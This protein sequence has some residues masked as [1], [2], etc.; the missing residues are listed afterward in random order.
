MLDICIKFTWTLWHYSLLI[1]FLGYE[2]ILKIHTKLVIDS[3]ES[4]HL[5]QSLSQKAFRC[6]EVLEE[7]NKVAATV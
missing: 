4:Q 5:L 1:W 6:V 2:R 3:L 7:K